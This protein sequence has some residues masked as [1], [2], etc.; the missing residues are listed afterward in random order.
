MQYTDPTEPMSVLGVPG[1]LTHRTVH[2]TTKPGCFFRQ[3]WASLAR[4]TGRGTYLK[5]EIRFDDECG[6]GHNSFAI[7]A[8]EKDPKVRR[9]GG[10]VACGC[11]HEEIARVFPELAPLIRWHLCSTDG[12]MHYI[13]NTLYLA[14]DRD[15]NGLR[16]GETRQRIGRDGAKL[17][18]LVADARPGARLKT[19]DPVGA[20]GTAPVYR[21]ETLAALPAGED[22]TRLVAPA[23]LWRPLMTIGEGKARELVR[24]RAVAC[25]PEATDEQLCAEPAELRAM[26]EARLPALIEEFRSVVE[27][28]GFV[29]ER[30]ADHAE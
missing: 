21:L 26:L 15:H 28:I 19:S 25:W 4:P 29:W 6:N 12:P 9:D 13:A 27:S 18:E 5:V 1:R 14:G 16:K 17:Y 2:P 11:M 3:R 23:L 20:D 7:T 24:A 8:E 30:I 22:Q 10:I